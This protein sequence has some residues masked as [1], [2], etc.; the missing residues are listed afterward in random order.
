MGF[1]NFAGLLVQ[2][3]NPSFAQHFAISST[4]CLVVHSVK[5][6]HISFAFL[7]K[8]PDLL[9]ISNKLLFSLYI[10]THARM[11]LVCIHLFVC[12]HN[13]VVYLYNLKKTYYKKLE[14]RD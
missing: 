7:E 10:F 13:Y 1:K 14:N 11:F 6:I 4:R 8:V 9:Y 5:F 2:M 3:R 12:A